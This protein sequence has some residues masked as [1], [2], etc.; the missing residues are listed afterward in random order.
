MPTELAKTLVMLAGALEHDQLGPTSEND[1]GTGGR[2][3]DVLRGLEEAVRR[4]K[5]GIGEGI[6]GQD[7]ATFEAIVS[8]FLVFSVFT[9]LNA[10]QSLIS[11]LHA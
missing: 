7:L 3:Q 2:Y 6:S 10:S 9:L 4:E 11:T 1:K 8:G 5:T